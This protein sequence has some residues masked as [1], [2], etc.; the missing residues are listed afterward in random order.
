M[1]RA[2]RYDLALERAEELLR[3]APVPEPRWEVIERGLLARIEEERAAAA[4]P[5]PGPS[6]LG[7]A[8]AFAAVAAAIALGISASGSGAR[9][10]AEPA[11]ERVVDV[12]AAAR[13][14]GGGGARGDLDARGLR[15]GDV[16]EAGG[17]AISLADPGSVRWT[18]APGGRAV[19]RAIG[20]GGVG[21]VVTLA[22]GS[23]RAEVTPRDPSEGLVEA[24][25]VEVDGTRVAVHGTIFTVT[26]LEERVEVDVERGAVAIGPAAYSGATNGHLLI[27]PARGEFSLDGGRVARLLPPAPRLAD[28]APPG[29]ALDPAA[30]LAAV[31]VRD[32][33]EPV[34]PA[35]IAL[36][37]PAPAG[38]LAAPAHAGT[39]A[40]PAPAHAGT[41]AAPEDHGAAAAPPEAAPAPA[42]APTLL[43]PTSIRASLAS[44]FATKRGGGSPSVQTKIMSTLRIK[45]GSDGGV[46]GVRFDPPLRPDLQACAQILYGGRFAPSA[47]PEI[48]VAVTIE[49]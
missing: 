34:A 22:R 16:I 17:E 1:S 28:A 40:A 19:V 48:A 36:A 4:R 47:G 32:P 26:R 43:T 5:A 29:P 3:A 12:A 37:A 33:S 13:V 49:E 25:A 9:V 18:L 21:A 44:C 31:D 20:A 30:G 38:P 27:G 11:P 10:T 46:A 8:A 2:R 23:L 15:P 41:S 14:A 42:P 39:S 7:R 45:I 35:P 24:F 6:W